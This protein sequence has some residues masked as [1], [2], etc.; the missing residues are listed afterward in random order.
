MVFSTSYYAGT[1]A[2]THYY[3]TAPLSTVNPTSGM[4]N[5]YGYL[6]VTVTT[7]IVGHA[8]WVANCPSCY[9]CRCG[10]YDYAV[11]YPG[12][13]WVS[14]HGL[15]VQNGA[16]SLHGPTVAYNHWMTSNAAYAYYFTTLDY[17]NAYGGT[18][19]SNDMALPFAGKFD[20]S[21]TWTAGEDHLSHEFGTAADTDSVPQANVSAFLGYCTYYLAVDARQEPNGSLHCRWPN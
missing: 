19:Y 1:N 2:H 7:T 8:E 14:D 18:I 15:V 16:T 12:I 6:A 17:H 11:G 5:G 13:Y 20:L 9:N 10:T 4:G 3:P 21:G